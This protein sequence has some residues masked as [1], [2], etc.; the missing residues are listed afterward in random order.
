MTNSSEVE[1]ENIEQWVTGD[2]TLENRLLT[3]EL[4]VQTVAEEYGKIDDFD[5]SCGTVGVLLFW[6]VKLMNKIK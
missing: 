2:D 6:G 5:E 1:E 3:D 4:I